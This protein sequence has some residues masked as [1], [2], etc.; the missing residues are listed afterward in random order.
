MICTVSIVKLLTFVIRDR[1]DLRGLD[2][3]PS[4]LNNSLNL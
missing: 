2:A 3:Q 4:V 1:L